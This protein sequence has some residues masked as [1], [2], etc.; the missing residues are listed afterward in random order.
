VLAGEAFSEPCQHTRRR[1]WFARLAERFAR[2][3]QAKA[4]LQ[5]SCL[6]TGIIK[7][8]ILVHYFVEE[9]MTSFSWLHL[10][11]LHRG[12]KEQHWLWPGVREIFFEDLKKLHEKCGPWDLVMFTGDLTQRGSAEEFQ[13]LN[14]L[15]DQLWE[16][17][18]KLGSSPRLLAVP[19]NHDLVR[20]DRKDPSVRLLQQWKDQLEIQ[21]EFW[22][23]AD[24]PY[25][26]VVTQ[27]FENYAA[28][29]NNQPH[30]VENVNP[31]ILPGDFS[32]SIEIEKEGA[33]LGI[34][35]LNASFL[36]L[37]DDDY[38]GKLTLHPRQFHGVCDGDGPAWAKQHHACLLLTHHPPAWLDDVSRKHLN[39]EISAHGRFA[40]HLCGHAHETVV[41]EFAEGGAQPR[42]LWQARS[43]FGLEYFGKDK[44]SRRLHGYTAG[45]IALE[46]NA[47][48]LLFWPRKDQRQGGQRSI[49]PDYS[50]QLTD[51]QHTH[52][53][54]FEPLQPYNIQ[55]EIQDQH[56]WNEQRLRQ[57]IAELQKQWDLLSEKLSGLEQDKILE[58]RSEERFR[59]EH[60]IKK[61]EAERQQIEQQLK[62]LESRLAGQKDDESSDEREATIET[63]DPDADAPPSVDPEALRKTYLNWLLET[64][65]QVFLGGI[66]RIAARKGAEASLNL[67][68]IYTA[69]RTLSAEHKAR[70]GAEMDSPLEGPVLSEVEGGQGG[71]FPSWEGPGVG[72]ERRLSAVAQLNRHARLVLLGDPGGG[73]STFVNFVAICMSGKQLGDPLV[74][75]DLLTAPLPDKEGKDEEE[76][77]PWQHGALL[78]VRVILRDFAAE[79]LPPVGRRGTAKHLWAF[80]VKTLEE[81]PFGDYASHL[82]CHLLETGG[83]VLLD[84]LDEVPEAHARRTQIKQVVE[85]FAHAFPLCRLLVT[86]RTYAYQ[87]QEWR[88]TGF[89]EAVLAS[90]TAGQIRRFVDRWYDHSAPLLGMR[91]DDAR[92]RAEQLKRAI[93]G[94]DRLYSFAERPLLLTLMAS[95]HAWRGGSLPEKRQELYDNAVD[96]LLDWWESRK[97]KDTDEQLLSLTEMLKLGREGMGGLRSLI[98]S[99]AYAAHE[100][101]P[102]LVGTADIAED[103]LAGGLMRLSQ[104]KDV[105][106]LRLVEF[107]RDRAGLL[108]SHGVGMYT[109]PHRTFQE[110]LAACHLTDQDDYPDNVAELARTDPNRWREVV[111]LAGAKVVRGAAA[112]IWFLADALCYR[113]ANDPQVTPEDAWGALLAGQALAE[114]ANLEKIS[115]RNQSKAERVRDWLVE[116]LTERKPSGSPLP[117]VERALAGNILAQLSDSRPG[118]GLREDSL[119][120]ISWCEVPAGI[121]VMGSDPTK[122]K[123]AMDREQPQHEVNLSAYRISRYPVTNAQYRVFVEDGGY[124]DKWR[125]CWTPEGWKWKE[126]RE[127]TEPEMSGGV[128]DLPNHPVVEVSWYEATAFCQWLTERLRETHPSPSQEGI[129][130][131]PSEA[132]WEKAARGDDG[133]IY[134]WGDKIDPNL[135]N[136][137]ETGLGATSAVGCFPSGASPYGCE[138]MAGNIYDWCADPWHENYKGAPE[139]GSVWEEGGNPGYRLLRGGSWYNLPYDVRCAD[140]LH[141]DPDL[142]NNNVGFRVV[143]V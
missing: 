95:L 53:I 13:K 49:V 4:A 34:V 47:G 56:D 58:T 48:T 11:D 139:D 125:H 5:H 16:C 74:N 90:F 35:G 97:V 85:D 31:G 126:Q 29:W 91:P 96:L 115:P 105:N 124:T 136:Y 103:K 17:F 88:L 87:K 94:S 141:G 19:G 113:N 100:A 123:D 64:C 81:T 28:W 23:E 80:I 25:R 128:F 1:V 54:R 131:L 65:S 6:I 101:Q 89:A 55:T 142:R 52:P 63:R 77:Q 122:D 129:I 84:G 8:P 61:I 38:E 108:V 104:N 120:D 12:M 68:A 98:G 114:T 60:K 137:V 20:P 78:P 30:K 86:S 32:A 57:Q 39:A 7:E 75:L 73:K 121:F 27:A 22:E 14:E 133:R 72:S 70:K 119:P 62:E 43:L 33:K 83:L 44:E 18:N 134:P 24:S 138:D 42:R 36:Q 109:F 130:R 50:V 59:L 143:F 117:A 127:L 45:R 9:S 66:D 71:V 93:F 118:V 37:T 111:L 10:T 76:P 102:D 21:K 2:A 67:G 99:L 40:V 46:G 106:P 51:E 69:L 112:S 140:R 107:L 26:Q 116:I 82:R 3:N 15:L 132:E 135:A 79:G 110:Y 41:R 92:G